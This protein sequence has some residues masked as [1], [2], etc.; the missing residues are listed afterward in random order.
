[1][2]FAESRG[3]VLE[4]VRRGVRT[5]SRRPVGGC[6]QAAEQKGCKILD[7][8]QLAACEHRRLFST[9]KT[10]HESDE[11]AHRLHHSR[12]GLLLGPSG[13]RCQQAKQQCP[14]KA[15]CAWSIRRPIG[16]MIILVH[17]SLR[18]E[19]AP[20]CVAHCSALSVSRSTS[21][22]GAAPRRPRA[23]L[24]TSSFSARWCASTSPYSA[25]DPRTSSS[26]AGI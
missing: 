23:S 20:R 15:V 17:L 16:P 4:V 18:I 26:T 22:I 21:T 24:T 10:A 3:Q 14:T 8:A 19:A 25:R 2:R 12:G 5:E 9:A 7:D 13:A 11:A 1:M 6:L